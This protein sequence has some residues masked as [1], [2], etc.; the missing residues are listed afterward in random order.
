M[1]HGSLDDGGRKKERKKW[2]EAETRPRRELLEARVAEFS[3]E[4]P[5]GQTDAEAEEKGKGKGEWAGQGCRF[6]VPSLSLFLSPRPSRKLFSHFYAFA[7]QLRAD[8]PFAPFTLVRPRAPSDSGGSV[9]QKKLY[10]LNS[11]TKVLFCNLFKGMTSPLQENCDFLLPSWRGGDLA[12]L[13]NCLHP[14]VSLEPLSQQFS[15]YNPRR[16]R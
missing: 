16:D 8:A 11:E 3:P 9:Q 15:C 4:C 6:A 7:G 13:L 12:E 14:E 5:R 1:D 10:P 2:H